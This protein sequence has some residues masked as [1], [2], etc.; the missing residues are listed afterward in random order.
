MVSYPC[1]DSLTC[2]LST[3]PS[4]TSFRPSGRWDT[5]SLYPFQVIKWKL[6]NKQVFSAEKHPANTALANNL[7]CKDLTR[8]LTQKIFQPNQ[9]CIHF[10]VIFRCIRR[11][12]CQLQFSLWL[13][14]SMEK[15]KIEKCSKYRT[16]SL[17]PSM[18]TYSVPLQCVQST[19][20][21]TAV[22]I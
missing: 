10:A 7:E 21:H 16:K 1:A 5:G 4:L 8:K 14:I 9:I 22:Q 11:Y 18:N 17:F 19:E 2:L 15:Q 6:I 3:S 20:S 13:L 12:V